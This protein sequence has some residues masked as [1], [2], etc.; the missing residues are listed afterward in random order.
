MLISVS[1]DGTNFVALNGGALIT[2]TLPANYYTNPDTTNYNAAPPANPTFADFG[3][4]FTGSLAD[5]NGETEAQ[6]L[7]TLEPLD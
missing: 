3:K 4:P 2:S 6:A 5:F 1:A 7:A